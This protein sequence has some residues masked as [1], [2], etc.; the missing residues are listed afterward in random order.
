MPALVASWSAAATAPLTPRTEL[1]GESVMRRHATQAAYHRVVSTPRACRRDRRSASAP[2]VTLVGTFLT[3]VRSGAT[4]RS[5]YDCSI[6]STGSASRLTGSWAGHCACGRSSRCCWCWPW[7]AWW[8]RPSRLWATAVAWRSPLVAALYA[9]GDS[10]RR[11]Q[12]SRH[13]PVHGSVR[14]GGDVDRRR[15]DDRRSRRRTVDAR[16]SRRDCPASVPLAAL[17]EHVLEHLRPIGHDPVD[18][19]VEQAPHL[20]GVVDRPDVD[21]VPAAMGAVDGRTE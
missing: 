20:V 17:Q 9:G 18:A 10:L 13:R 15:R 4:G 7:S 2:L 21:L 19:Q 1:V 6:S 11:R 12:R 16:L 3:W 8:H 14:T 5:S